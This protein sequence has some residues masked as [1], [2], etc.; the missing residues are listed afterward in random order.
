MLLA[1]FLGMVMSVQG[2][3]WMTSG[4]DHCIERCHVGTRKELDAV[5]WCK[6]VDGVA[7]EHRPGHEEESLTEEDK[8]MWDYCTPATVEV[9]EDGDGYHETG[10]ASVL[11]DR[12]NKTKRQTGMQ[13]LNGKLQ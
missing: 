5:L 1:V 7:T 10:E 8:Y 12:V 11:P 9:V 2:A 3:E 4:G 13:A 6:V